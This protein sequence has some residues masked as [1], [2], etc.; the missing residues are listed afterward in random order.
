MKRTTADIGRARTAERERPAVRKSSIAARDRINYDM[1]RQ[2]AGRRSPAA[3]DAYVRDELGPWLEI[4]WCEAYERTVPG[5]E[6]LVVTLDTFTYLFD[7]DRERAIGVYGVMTGKNAAPRPKSRMRGH[8]KAAGRHWHRGHMIPH[9]GHGGTDINLFDQRGAINVGAFRVLEN[10]AVANEGSF[11]F[12]R[13][14]YNRGSRLQRP[15]WVEQGLI[16][17]TVPPRI[18]IALFPN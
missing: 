10:L 14:I 8:P 7:L 1:L 4:L 15:D 16:R 13:L 2:Q 12:V 11:Y 6:I 9:S 18:D 17:K 3:L 5:A